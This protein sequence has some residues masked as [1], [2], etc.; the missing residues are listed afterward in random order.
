MNTWM[1][2]GGGN[3]HM[4]FFFFFLGRSHTWNFWGK[5]VI[6]I[7]VLNWWLRVRWRWALLQGVL[8]NIFC[9]RRAAFWPPSEQ[10]MLTVEVACQLCGGDL[11]TV[12]FNRISTGAGW[13]LSLQ[14]ENTQHKWGQIQFESTPSSYTVFNIK[15]MSTWIY[16]MGLT[17]MNYLNLPPKHISLVSESNHRSHLLNLITLCRL[18]HFIVIYVGSQSK[19]EIEKNHLKGVLNY[20]TGLIPSYVFQTT[21]LVY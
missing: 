7:R 20:F 21:K 8:Q 6:L 9:E 11:C 4:G 1:W 16:L 17:W 2:A 19:F 18:C 13:S 12:H 14:G 3:S 5:S 10:C 15:K